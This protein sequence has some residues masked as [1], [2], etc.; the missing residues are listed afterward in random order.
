M[1]FISKVLD[2]DILSFYKILHKI[3]Y[4]LLSQ[5]FLS[6]MFMHNVFLIFV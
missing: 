2:F 1:F 3:K 4:Y 5:N 6:F